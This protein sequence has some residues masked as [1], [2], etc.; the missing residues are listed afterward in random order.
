MAQAEKPIT[1]YA[2]PKTK[3]MKSIFKLKLLYI[4]VFFTSFIQESFYSQEILFKFNIDVNKNGVITNH[5]QFDF[6]TNYPITFGN[7]VASTNLQTPLP[8]LCSGDQLIITNLCFLTTSSGAT[9]YS[10]SAATNNFATIGL[11]TN[12]GCTN[13]NTNAGSTNIVNVYPLGHVCNPNTVSGNTTIW[14]DWNYNTSKTVTIPSNL[15]SSSNYYLMISDVITPQ[16]TPDCYCYSKFCFKSLTIGE[17]PQGIDDQLLCAGESVDL[18]LNP[19]YTYSGWTP[20]NPDNTVISSTTNYSVSINSNTTLCSAIIDDFQL[21]VNSGPITNLL[22]SNTV[23]ICNTDLPYSIDV[24]VNPNE[25]SSILING[26]VEFELYGNI[27]NTDANGYLWINSIGTHVITY[28]YIIPST[29]QVCSKEYTIIVGRKPKANLADYSLCTNDPMPVL[30]LF[31][32][33]AQSYNW[34]YTPTG[35]LPISVGTSSNLNTSSF[36]YG[37]YEVEVTGQDAWCSRIAQSTVVL[38]QSAA[39]NL[40]ASFNWNEYNNSATNKTDFTLMSNESGVHFWIFRTSQNGVNWNNFA[41]SGFTTNPI[42]SVPNVPYNVWTKKIHLVKR[43]PC[44]EWAIDIHTQFNSKKKGRSTINTND[45]IV[46]ESEFQSY[47]ELMNQYESNL[48]TSNLYPNPSNGLV[49]I[50]FSEMVNLSEIEIQ[51]ITGKTIKNYSFSNANSVEI[52]LSNHPAGI[53][54]AK[55]LINGNLEIKKIQIR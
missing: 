42:Y 48:I 40:D 26:N 15:P 37:T 13:T 24:Y 5:G 4:A 25:C 18:N 1:E 17:T 20:S 53:Y 51:D 7:L 19:N 31:S 55:I 38:D 46:S 35:L 45:K 10:F 36:G 23:E 39:A 12:Y 27:D 11:T 6:H 33:Y 52:N 29:G 8:S 44:N 41:I 22:N 16:T 54:F 30:N 9:P 43:S 50:D 34:T 47:I 14:S 21:S 3:K 49:N 28:E 32:I 2:I